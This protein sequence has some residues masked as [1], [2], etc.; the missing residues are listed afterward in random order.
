MPDSVYEVVAQA[1]RY[2]FLFLM[3][4]IVW[5]SYRW[6]ARDRKQRRKRLRLLP[7]AGFVGELVVL[8]GSDELPA[9]L[10]LPVSR[11]GVLGSVRGDDLYVPVRGVAKR[12]LWYVFEEEHGLRVQPLGRR[13]AQVDGAALEGRHARAYLAHGSRLRVGEAELRLRMFAGFEQAGSANRTAWADEP[14]APDAAP[15]AAPA[16][17]PEGAAMPPAA[18]ASGLPPQPTPEQLAAFQQLQWMAAWQAWQAWQAQQGQAGATPVPDGTPAAPP[19]L[20]TAQGDFTAP[21]KAAPPQALL[22]DTPE[23]EP[24]QPA[25]DAP[26]GRVPRRLRHN[27]L[28]PLEAEGSI[29]PDDGYPDAFDPSETLPAQGDADALWAQTHAPTPEHTLHMSAA[30]SEP[31]GYNPTFAPRV[32]FYPPEMD[33]EPDF[34]LPPDGSADGPADAPA[35]SGEEAWPYAPYPQSDAHFANTGYTYPEY[36]EPESQPYEYADEDEAPRSLYLEPDEAAK[37]KQMLWDR[38]L[39]GGRRP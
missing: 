6:L 24:P 12:H 33:A 20:H 18:V 30:T 4:L 28:P 21:P 35:P 38:Y 11:E 10:A 34:E 29:A 8:S 1:A 37:A 26:E 31:D 15:Q 9:G 39:K 23:D 25:P 19:L 36:V 7:D 27:P 13:A 2:W 22:T 17:P 16:A 3:V 5:R 14:T 32:A